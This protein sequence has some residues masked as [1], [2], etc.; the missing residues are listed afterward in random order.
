MLRTLRSLTD[1]ARRLVTSLRYKLLTL[2]TSEERI[3]FLRSQGVR[4]GEGCLVF[5]SQFSENPYL[6]EI[7]NRVAISAGTVFVTHDGSVWLFEEHPE[8]DV[9]GTIRI[10]DNVYIGLDCTLLPNTVIGSNCIIG[11]GSV[12][13]GVIP[14]DSVVFGNPARVVMKTPMAKQLL[15]NSKNRLETRHLPPAEKHRVIRQHFGR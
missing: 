7:G 1:R 4:I 15:V 12:V 3:R 6:V 8:M 13:R 10:G 14:D 5:T 9:F 11:A 2:A